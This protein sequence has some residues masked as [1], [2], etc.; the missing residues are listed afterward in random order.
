MS[1][2]VVF[3]IKLISSVKLDLKLICQCDH[4]VLCTGIKLR[5]YHPSD[6]G[7][8]TPDV[9]H[10]VID[11]VLE[12]VREPKDRPVLLLPHRLNKA[13]TQY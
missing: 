6:G 5:Y 10:W 3:F 8:D 12:L 2:C 7:E 1:V 11:E 9:Q 4:Q 13:V